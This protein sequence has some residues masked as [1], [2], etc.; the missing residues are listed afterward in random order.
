MT[1]HRPAPPS[2]PRPRV[3]QPHHRRAASNASAAHPSAPRAKAIAVPAPRVTLWSAAIV[4]LLLSGTWLAAVG[5]W[6]LVRG[7]TFG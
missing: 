5:L 1:Q 2:P 4:A 6:H 3:A 7:V